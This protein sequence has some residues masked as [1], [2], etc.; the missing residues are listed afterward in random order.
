MKWP[1]KIKML[2]T[3]KSSINSTTKAQVQTKLAGEK[4]R[5]DAKA[6]CLAEKL[7]KQKASEKPRFYYGWYGSR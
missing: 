4:T 2:L 3:K 5:T 6:N 7:A 1:E